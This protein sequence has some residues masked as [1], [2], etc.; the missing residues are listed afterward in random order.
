MFPMMVAISAGLYMT[1][2]ES[3]EC[4]GN[5]KPDVMKGRI[6]GTQD[7]GNDPNEDR[8]SCF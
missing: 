1:F 2:N 3:S 7:E 5:L 8:I 6:M 4:E